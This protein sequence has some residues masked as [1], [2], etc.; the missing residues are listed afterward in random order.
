MV[1]SDTNKFANKIGFSTT[2]IQGSATPWLRLLGDGGSGE[3]M[4]RI[5][6]GL[7]VRRLCGLTAGARVRLWLDFR[8]RA[9]R[10][11]SQVHL[12]ALASISY[13]LFVDCCERGRFL[14][15]KQLHHAEAVTNPP[16]F[17][18]ISGEDP[19]QPMHLSLLTRAT[20]FALPEHGGARP[21]Q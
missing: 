4:C 18:L 10:R 9:G 5:C 14:P 12:P 11:T 19:A 2:A 20:L 15:A 16:T 1:C 21:W 13:A 17:W 8:E 6:V 3:G 7:R